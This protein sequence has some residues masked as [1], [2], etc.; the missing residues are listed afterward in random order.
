MCMYDDTM[1]THARA[2]RFHHQ[3]IPL[4]LLLAGSGCV[5]KSTL[6]TYLAER[7][8]L[9]SVL[10]TDWIHEVLCSQGYVRG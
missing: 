2:R 9:P 7:L 10:K 3:R 1:C 4:I 5:G 8:N 6:A